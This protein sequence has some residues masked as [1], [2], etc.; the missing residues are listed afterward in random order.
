MRR[1]RIILTVTL[2]IGAAFLLAP[3]AAMAGG[4]VGRSMVTVGAAGVRGGVQPGSVRHQGPSVR[5]GGSGEAVIQA[6]QPGAP[7]NFVA[8]PSGRNVVAPG[9]TVASWVFA[10]PVVYAVPSG[11]DAPPAYDSG[12]PAYYPPPA[13]YAAPV[14][15]VVVY[16]P[17]PAP[18]PMPTVVEFSTGRY[19]LRGDGI[20]TAYVWVWIPNPPS[21]PPTASTLV[22]IP[23]DPP[24]AGLQPLY[25][26]TDDAG[27][28]HW[29]D[30]RDVVPERHRVE[31]EL[32]RI[33]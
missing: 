31:A 19:E 14:E 28:A 13:S 11:Y 33:P 21:A 29:T 24:R 30:R 15:N 18:P 10:S 9:M 7:G 23:E 8:V 2:C 1:G 20:T 17:S 27:V 32:P 3:V 22:P 6:I 26:W 25:R 16:A 12:P 4:P 5:H